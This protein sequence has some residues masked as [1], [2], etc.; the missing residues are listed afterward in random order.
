[1]YTS[2]LSHENLTHVRKHTACNLCALVSRCLHTL[3]SKLRTFVLACQRDRKPRQAGFRHHV[4]ANDAYRLPTR[5]RGIQK[6]PI[7]LH[8]LQVF[9]NILS[10]G[11]GKVMW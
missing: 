5:L 7:F 8:L 11:M 1:M 2:A 4:D 3:G 6:E 9:L 10:K